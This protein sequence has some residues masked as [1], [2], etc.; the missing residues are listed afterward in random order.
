MAFLRSW[1]F[2]GQ[3]LCLILEISWATIRCV[4]SELPL[5]FLWLQIPAEFHSKTV[6]L[7]RK[8]WDFIRGRND[9]LGPTQH[10]ASFTS[11]LYLQLLGAQILPESD[12]PA[13]W[14]IQL[15]TWC[16]V[17]WVLWRDASSRCRFPE[18]HSPPKY[19]EKS[20]KGLLVIAHSAAFLRVRLSCWQHKLWI[21]F[22]S[23]NPFTIC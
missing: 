22:S 9:I 21:A 3:D 23:S 8:F 19:Q 13:L 15:R 20:R 1:G 6:L 14:L 2:L 16:S 12:S 5:C 4:L 10:M 18:R 7:G 11:H 17:L